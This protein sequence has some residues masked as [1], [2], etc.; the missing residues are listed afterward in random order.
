MVNIHVSAPQVLI[1]E[2]EWLLRMELATALEEAGWR[3]LEAE[4]GERAL[5]ILEQRPL[6][7]VLIT[8][9]RLGGA[10]NGWDVAD[11]AR[12]VSPLLPVIYVSANSPDVNRQV[13]Q[14]TFFSKPVP[15]QKLLWVIAAFTNR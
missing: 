13:A 4:S 9:I 3:V 2:D 10:A 12:V 7:N 1:V 11:A 14:S 5:A 6:L 15:L 8:D